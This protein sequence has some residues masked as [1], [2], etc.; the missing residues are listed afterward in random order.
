MARV[1]V[2]GAGLSGL[3][4]ARALQNSGA[5][6]QV[7]ESS[8]D[9]GGRVRTD[10][11]E[12]YRL[13]RGFQVLLQAYPA[14]K[15]DLDLAALRV[16]RWDP[17]AILIAQ[18]RQYVLADPR[19]VPQ[20][21]LASAACPLFAMSDKI[22]VL[23]M[24]RRLLAIED[25]DLFAMPDEPMA[26]YLHRCGFSQ[27]FIEMFIA[28]FFGGIFLE[29]HLETSVRMFAF[30]WKMLA[31]GGTCVPEQ[32]MGAIPHQIAS[33]LRPGSI[34][35][36]SAISELI[37]QGNKVVGLRVAG[38]VIPAE[39]VILATPFDV[40]AK[41]LGIDISLKWRQ[42]TTLYYSVPRPLY[43]H[44]LITL[45]TDPRRL[46]NNV[47]MVTNVAPAYAPPGKHLLCCSI[48]Q[49]STLTD[50]E[51]DAAVRREIGAAYANEDTRSWRL[52]KIY[53][54]AN[55]QFE[56]RPG[57]WQQL[58]LLRKSAPGVIVAGEAT[59]SSSIEGALASG[60]SAADRVLNNET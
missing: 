32:G 16:C 48:S 31:K 37:R 36:N 3:A 8:D 34:L 35:L 6:V 50:D 23:Q 17:G 15:R 54:I 40:T 33:N 59:V 60:R 10:Y 43:T 30:V 27:S 14:V 20:L 9:V 29:T 13:D 24:T 47:A 56:Q 55:A 38:D 26:D 7:Y 45:L 51:L 44:R 25:K 58:E 22:R 39:I 2:V 53:R 18:G 19:R 5:D 49:G 4:C 11:V 46:V 1:V 28:P 42:S 57:V 12:G 52:L 21:A 41:L